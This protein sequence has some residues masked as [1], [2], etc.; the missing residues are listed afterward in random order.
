MKIVVGF[1]CGILLTLM[2]GGFYVDCQ[3]RREV[4]EELVRQGCRPVQVIR[5]G[6]PDN[7]RKT[8]VLPDGRIYSTNL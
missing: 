2:V 4:Y 7:R 1:G 3:H 6:H 8:C 5:D